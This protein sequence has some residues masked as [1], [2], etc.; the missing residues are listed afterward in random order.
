MKSAFVKAEMIQRCLICS[1]EQH[2][3]RSVSEF[4]QHLQ[5]AGYLGLFIGE[6]AGEVRKIALNSLR[7]P[8]Q[9]KDSDE[10]PLPL[11]LHYNKIW[12]DIKT[13]RV[14]SIFATTVEE[15]LPTDNPFRGTPIT[16]CMRHS[17]NLKEFVDAI[18]SAIIKEGGSAPRAGADVDNFYMSS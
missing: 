1:R 10:G 11:P 13:S 18:N 14:N 12:F 5:E 6:I 16:K 17:K 15:L 2:F 7:L 8:T 4:V 3:N 9:E